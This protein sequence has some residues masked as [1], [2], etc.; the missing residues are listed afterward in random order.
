MQ[1]LSPRPLALRVAVG[2]TLISSGRAMTLAFIARAGDG[3]PGDPPEAWLMPLIGDAAVGLTAPLVAW[4]LWQRPSPTTWIVAISWS[5]VAAFDAV[6]A[7]IVDVS[8][9]WPEFF[10]LEV[11]GRAMFFAAAGLHIVIIVLLMRPAT[12]SHRGVGGTLAAGV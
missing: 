6:A 12:R 7:F 4:L 2:L 5:T 11:F 8:T 10:M 3:G 1:A 9:P